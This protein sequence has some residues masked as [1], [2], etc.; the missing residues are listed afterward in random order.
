MAR[1]EDVQDVLCLASCVSRDLYESAT[2]PYAIGSGE[3]VQ[4]R[5]GVIR[6]NFKFVY[7][8]Y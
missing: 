6:Y 3:P 1:P 7:R 8:V 5:I 4:L 2:L